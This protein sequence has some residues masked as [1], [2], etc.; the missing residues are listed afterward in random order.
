ML[1][2][3]WRTAGDPANLA[4]IGDIDFEQESRT[5][6]TLRALAAAAR[7]AIVLAAL[8]LAMGLGAAS[9][10][11]P[12]QFAINVDGSGNALHGYD[13]VA[14]FTVGKA[15]RGDPQLNHTWQG[16]RWLFASASHRDQFAAEPERF[17]PRIGGFCAVGAVNGR[18]A[19]IDPEQWLIIR[20]RLYLY[21]NASVRKIALDDLEASAAAA[22][23]NWE[24]IKPAR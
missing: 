7:S 13:A 2:A 23:A 24:R 18:M 6:S 19:E 21:L 22:E 8:V 11:A 16:A 10:G 9:W 14:Y 12:N 3:R 4:L 5:M 17:A 20:G 1:R 15:V